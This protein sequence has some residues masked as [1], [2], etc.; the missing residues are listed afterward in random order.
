MAE[1]SV[2][3]ITHNEAENIRRCIESAKKVSRDIIV[4]DD[5]STDQTP[6]I[7]REMGVRFE[8]KAW[9]GY[10]SNKNYGNSLAKN[11]WILSID[12]DEE[13]SDKLAE[14]LGSAP[15][16]DGH[17]AFELAFISNYCGRWIRHGKWY[18]EYHIRLF[19]R[20]SVRWNTDEVHEGLIF[21]GTGKAPRLKGYVHHYSMH[22]IQHHL[23]KVNLYSSLA[24]EKMKHKGIKP[25]FVKLYL[26]PVFK[27]VAD[28]YF[29]MGFL[30]GFYGF[31][32]AVITSFEAYLKYAK[33]K[34]LYR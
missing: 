9:E 14:N 8:Q 12:A 10:G 21:S 15:L 2:V 31:T 4:I 19:N 32:I 20:Q 30:D 6:Q 22:S 28:Y 18:P 27:F 34:A 5:F 26:S 23:R 25:S 16:D 11:D 7:C 3:I 1:I 33:L 24:A 17:E 29:R 13:V